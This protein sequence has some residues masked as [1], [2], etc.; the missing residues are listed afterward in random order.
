MVAD[1]ILPGPFGY[2]AGQASVGDIFL[3]FVRTAVPG[4]Y[5]ERDVFERLGEEAAG[6]A[7]GTSGLLWR[8]IVVRLV[9]P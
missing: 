3:W 5:E 2:E 7:P 1:G 6:I 4:R 8:R 9:L